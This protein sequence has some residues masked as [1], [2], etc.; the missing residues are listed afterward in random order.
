MR[1]SPRKV[2]RVAVGVLLRGDGAVLLADRPAGKPYAGYWEFPGGKIESGEPVAV[3]LARELHEELGIETGPSVPWVTFDYDYPHAYV[4]LHFRCIYR[5]HGEPHAREGQRLQFVHPTGRLPQPLLPAA[6]PAL[7]WLRL[8]GAAWIV[9]SLDALPVAPGDGGGTRLVVIETDW[10]TSAPERGISAWR[11]AASRAGDVLIATGP[12]AEG[13]E[14]ADGV[15]LERLAP[16]KARG[17]LGQRWRGAWID[18]I[19]ESIDALSAGVDFVLV[20]RGPASE[21]VREQTA[22]PTYFPA[23]LLDVSLSAVREVVHWCWHDL[24]RGRLVR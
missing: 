8:P 15:L 20:R 16:I 10:R 17:G 2:T 11:D 6:V 23:S 1:P 13:T 19:D 12:G 18:A 22:V 5:W 24:R 14:G 9:S 4:R 3:A 21:A 7:R